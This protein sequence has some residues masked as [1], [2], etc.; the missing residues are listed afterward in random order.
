MHSE[1][2]LPGI[3]FTNILQEALK[4]MRQKL[5]CQIVIREKLHKTLWYKKSVRTM[6]VK[7]TPV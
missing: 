7:L 5:K 4:P 6:V 2:C 1:A 3:N